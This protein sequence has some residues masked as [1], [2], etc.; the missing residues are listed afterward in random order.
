MFK[1]IRTAK[2]EQV[3]ISVQS[4]YEGHHRVT[5]KGIKSDGYPFDYVI[6]Q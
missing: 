1:K 5:Y 6:Y 4:I 3:K 2:D